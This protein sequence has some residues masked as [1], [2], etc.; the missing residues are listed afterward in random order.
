MP[1]SAACLAAVPRLGRTTVPA[2]EALKPCMNNSHFGA[3]R[4]KLMHRKVRVGRIRLPRVTGRSHRFHCAAPPQRRRCARREILGIF[5]A[6]CF[7]TALAV[8]SI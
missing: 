1:I 8:V 7:T 3:L 6:E 4:H 5:I 2:A